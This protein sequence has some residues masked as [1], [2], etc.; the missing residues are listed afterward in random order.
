MILFIVALD[1]EK[2]AKLASAFQL[3]IFVLLNLAV[4]VMRESGLQSYDPG[5]RSPLYPG[6]QLI[7]FLV[8]VWL[9][10]PLCFL[11]GFGGSGQIVNFALAR[12][13]TRPQYSGTAIGVVNALVTGAGA[14]FQ[15]A[16]GWVL[17]RSW[18]GAVSGGARIYTEDAYHSS[19]P[20]IAVA[21]DAVIDLDGRFGLHPAL[22]PVAPLVDEGRLSIVHA[23]GSPDKDRSHFS[24]QAA[25]E[26]GLAGPGP[27][28]LG[29][30]GR[31]L[32]SSAGT[33]DA[34]CALNRRA[35]SMCTANP[36]RRA[37]ATSSS[38][39]SSGTTVPPA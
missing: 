30:L 36:C 11:T 5:F 31:H 32:S 23:V 26:Q 4:I 20:S 39:R 13:H 19:R 9:V 24:A 8:P 27:D 16:V 17:D 33:P 25:A 28:G 10:G 3:F 38:R 22:A 15:P 7:G 35:P 37:T 14:L 29:W 6:M 12:E 1:A 34:T 18:S 2:I 21:A